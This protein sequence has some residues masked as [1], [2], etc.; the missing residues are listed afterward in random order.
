MNELLGRTLGGITVAKARSTIRQDA[1][2][3]FKDAL[4]AT[5]PKE[6]SNPTPISRQAGKVLLACDHCGLTFWRKSSHAGARN[7]CGRGCSSAAQRKRV[8]LTCSICDA[9]YLV[10]P[11]AANKGRTT[12]GAPVCVH[13]RQKQ[14]AEQ[15]TR[16]IGAGMFVRPNK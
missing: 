3:I 7:F 2:T 4:A 16:E 1:G 5:S 8:S 12:C 9:D 14:V 11:A 10:W 6:L 15:R 13:A